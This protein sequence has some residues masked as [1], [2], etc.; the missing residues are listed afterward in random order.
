MPAPAPASAELDFRR[1]FLLPLVGIILAL[2]FALLGSL[3]WLTAEEDR[4]EAAKERQLVTTALAGRV[5]SIRKNLGDYAIWDDAVAN[6]VVAFDRTWATDNIAPY[7]FDVQGYEH[8]FVLDSRDRTIHGSDRDKLAR[9]NATALLGPAFTDALRTLRSRPVGTDQRVAGFTTVRGKPAIFGVAQL[10]PSTDKVRL[11]GGPASLIVF[12]K[13]VDDPF[14]SALAKDY[15]LTGVH[16]A[17]PSE[18]GAL[19]L[20]DPAGRPLGAIHWHVLTP[21]AD[22]F[23]QILPVAL[24]L[25]AAIAVAAWAL[26]RRAREAVATVSAKSREAAAEARTART[27]L[28]DLEA[29]KRRLLDEEGRARASLERVVAEVRGENERLNRQVEHERRT[30]LVEAA[31]AFEREVGDVADAVLDAAREL[32]SSA[33]SLSEIAANTRVEAVA[34][35]TTA[36]QASRAVQDV[37]GAAADLRE[38]IGRIAGQVRSQSDLTAQAETASVQGNEVVRHLAGEAT[39]IGTVVGSIKRIAG[40]TNLLALNATIEA[41][42]A[43]AAGAGFSVVAGEVKNLAG[44]TAQA[45]GSIAALVDGVQDRVEE[46]VASF[47]RVS[48]QVAQVSG[49]A[50]AI[51]DAV[52]DQR[53]ATAAIGRNAAQAANGADDV[54]GRIGGVARQVEAAGA[55][56]ERVADASIQLAARA[57][58][59]REASGGFV[60]RLRAA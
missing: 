57:E 40:Q 28:S 4:I 59:L 21:G 34:V 20:R 1:H 60:R 48:G 32:G 42:R 8:V 22:L 23:R 24:L 47:Q 55:L 46:A 3:T 37:A 58:Q 29:A 9:L 27:A 7:L 51:A 11:P 45:T 53:G 31:A 39:G 5:E 30:T 14:L 19:Q 43:G 56:T 52:E 50:A 12:V 41:A 13:R 26:L 10:M 44:Q 25:L 38:S 54:Q 35:A 15:N 17:D 36:A 6:L 2:G 16:L 18:P 33:Q 49:I